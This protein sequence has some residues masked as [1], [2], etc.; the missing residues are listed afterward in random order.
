LKFEQEGE[1]V[2]LNVRGLIYY[3][4]F[5]FTSCIIGTDAIV[6]YHD[7]MTTG[8]N[9]ENDGDFDKLSSNNLLNCKE[10]KLILLVYARVEL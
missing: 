1:T 4:N 5:H 7:G 3:G 2:V 8:S 6:W 10:S 9:C